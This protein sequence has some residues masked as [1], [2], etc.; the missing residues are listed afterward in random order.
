MLG[1]R[2]EHAV[3]HALVH[4]LAQVLGLR[5]RTHLGASHLD[6]AFILFREHTGSPVQHERLA[7]R[8]VIFQPRQHR[9]LK[10]YP[11]S[12]IHIEV[13]QPIA[14]R[15]IQQL[16]LPKPEPRLG[17][18]NLRGIFRADQPLRTPAGPDPG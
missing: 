5:I 12:P 4:A 16:P 3:K 17:L 8:Q 6:T 2:A 9:T 11:V 10:P 7:R 15:K 1:I 18:L 13:E 14:Q